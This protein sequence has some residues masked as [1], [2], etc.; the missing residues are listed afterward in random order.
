MTVRNH[1]ILSELAQFAVI[2]SHNLIIDTTLL[3]LTR[4]VLIGVPRHTGMSHISS[5]LRVRPQGGG[6][7][8]RRRVEDIPE[9]SLRSCSF[10]NG[11]NC[12][13]FFRPKNAGNQEKRVK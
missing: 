6:P 10:G 8:R 5:L 3:D 4:D 12:C 11:K 7:L 9:H 13:A 1:L 2:Q